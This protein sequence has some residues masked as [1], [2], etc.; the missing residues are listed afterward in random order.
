MGHMLKD[1]MV[2]GGDSCVETKKGMCLLCWYCSKDVAQGYANRWCRLEDPG[3][4]TRKFT[5]EHVRK[6]EQE[7]SRW[8]RET[9]SSGGEVF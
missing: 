2:C 3:K 6:T 5:F 8:N 4:T 1:A 7:F 9:P